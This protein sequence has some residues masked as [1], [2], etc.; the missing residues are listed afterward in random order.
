MKMFHLEQKKKCQISNINEDKVLINNF[1]TQQFTLEIHIIA[2]I[3][4]YQ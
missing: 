4:A 3:Y 2:Q 1:I